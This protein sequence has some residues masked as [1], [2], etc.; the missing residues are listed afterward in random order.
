MRIR[1]YSTV[2]NGLHYLSSVGTVLVVKT[3]G[4]N[5]CCTIVHAWLQI[6]ETAYPTD[7]TISDCFVEKDRIVSE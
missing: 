7:S 6:E 5:A 4:R 3:N 1:I 2:Y